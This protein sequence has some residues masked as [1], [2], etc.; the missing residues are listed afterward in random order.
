M[1]DGGP[2]SLLCKDLER[3]PGKLIVGSAVE[4]AEIEA[5]SSTQSLKVALLGQ[6][7][8]TERFQE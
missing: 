3:K 2:T 8:K 7:S 1:G 5:S 4:K 6:G